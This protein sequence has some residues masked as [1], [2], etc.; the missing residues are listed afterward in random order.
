M[1]LFYAFVLM[2]L[3]MTQTEEETRGERE[4]RKGTKVRGER[5]Q[6]KREGQGEHLA[7]IKQYSIVE[8]S[9]SKYNSYQLIKELRVNT[10]RH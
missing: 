7:T 6:R 3:A 9:E 2:C 8:H 1:I 5:E 4:T 10:Y